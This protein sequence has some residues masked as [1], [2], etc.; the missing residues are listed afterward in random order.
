MFR[1]RAAYQEYIWNICV[2]N[3]LGEITLLFSE[4]LYL[5]YFYCLQYRLWCF[6]VV[7]FFFLFL[8]AVILIYRTYSWL[9]VLFSLLTTKI[10]T[11][12]SSVFACS[13]GKMWRDTF[14]VTEFVKWSVFIFRWHTF[15]RNCC[16]QCRFISHKRSEKISLSVGLPRLRICKIIIWPGLLGQFFQVLSLISLLSLGAPNTLLYISRRKY[17]L[18][19]I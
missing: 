8:W 18:K 2:R 5:V 16:S 9:S 10:L 6:Y 4:S 15:V 13:L 19:N 3:F 1:I 12:N 14:L 17:D 7:V 11:I